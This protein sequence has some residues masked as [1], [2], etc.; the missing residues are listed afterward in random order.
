MSRSIDKQQKKTLEV[1]VVVPHSIWYLCHLLFG[2]TQCSINVSL[3]VSS[4]QVKVFQVLRVSKLLDH[5]MLFAM[6]SIVL[7]A[8]TILHHVII[9]HQI[10]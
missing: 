7:K 5:N 10:P 2:G 9:R 6:H 3:N 4:Y 8:I 1:I